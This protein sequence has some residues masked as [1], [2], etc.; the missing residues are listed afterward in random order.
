MFQILFIKE[1]VGEKTIKMIKN[2]YRSS[3]QIKLWMLSNEDFEDEQKYNDGFK[4]KNK[5]EYDNY[6][7]FSEDYDEVLD[8]M[9]GLW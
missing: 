2:F 1:M 8:E 7:I 6:L 9:D 3:Y 5:Y 4:D